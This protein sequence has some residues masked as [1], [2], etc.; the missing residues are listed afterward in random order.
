MIKQYIEKVNA[1]NEKV[2]SIFLTAGF[3]HKNDFVILAEKVLQAGADMLEIGI[4]FSDPLADGQVIQFS[5]QAALESGI[6][7]EDAFHFAEE[8]RKKSDKP[9]IAMTYANIVSNYGIDKFVNDASSSGLNGVIIPDLS[10]D[11]YDKFITFQR[12]DFDIVLLTTPTSSNERIIALD[13]K[14]AGF[15]Y[16]VSVTGTTGTRNGFTDEDISAMQKTRKLISKNKM[17]AGFGISS[18]ENILQIKNY[19]NGVIVGS[20]VIKKLISNENYDSIADFVSELKKAC[21]VTS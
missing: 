5:S 19:C 10:L 13:E 20:A 2:L 8:I 18:P 12:D 6:T 14:S 9:L 17:L 3:P 11:E 16:Y 4:P 15:I 1:G 21:R 7:V